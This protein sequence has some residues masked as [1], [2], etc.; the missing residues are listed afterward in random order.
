MIVPTYNGAA[1]LAECLT[2]V[3]A[4]TYQNMTCIVVDDGSTDHTIAMLAS[5]FP[6]VSVT[7]LGRNTGLACA[8]NTAIRASFAE[9]VVLLNNDAV[10]EPNWLAALVA[11]ADRHPTAGSIASRMRLY[12]RHDQLHSAGDTYSV[13]GIP[14]NRGVWQQDGPAFNREEEVWAA[15]AGA[16]LYRR[17]ALEQ[18]SLDGTVFDEALFM[19]CEDVDLGWRL[20]LNGYPCVYAPDAI[21]YHRLSATGGGPMAS[22]WCGRNFPRVLLANVPTPLLTRYWRFMLR[23]QFKLTW[24]AI[25]HGREPAARAQLRGQFRAIGD[26]PK[27]LKRRGQVQAMSVVDCNDL[28]RRLTF[29]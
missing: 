6:S 20:Q 4:Q 15:C 23:A 27:V 8:T 7:Q 2:A 12:D 10:P 26:I 11:T 5:Q 9:F 14:G 25:V 21:V 17:S 22:Y 3:A 19:Y 13:S 18:V 29:P 28:E 16:A 1:L 24:E